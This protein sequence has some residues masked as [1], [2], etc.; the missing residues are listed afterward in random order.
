MTSSPHLLRRWIGLSLRRLR[1]NAGK[2]RPEAAARLGVSRAAIGHMETARSLPSRAT[3]EIL[4]GFYGAPDRLD[5]FLRLTETAR[6]RRRWWD[7]LADA[8]PDWFDLYLG[9]EFGATEMAVF[10]SYVVPGILQTPAYAE[11]VVRG[12]PALT[13]EQVRRRV[14]LRIGRQAILHRA[15]DPVRLWVVLDESVLHR[16]RGTPEVMLEQIE[17][18]IAMSERPRVTLQILPLDAGAHLAQQGGFQILSFPPE[19]V[20]D[21][22]VV[23]VDQL[24]EGRYFE[25]PEQVDAYRRAMNQLRMRA[26]SPEESRRILCRA[27]KEVTA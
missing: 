14:E 8:V 19:F 16:R 18:L 17:H 6:K 1:K 20:D 10:G 2:S 13:D 3:L 23:Y 21:P 15:E 22:G 12:D 27:V 5:D 25:A 4:L 7:H 9:L 26:A 24:P 11:A